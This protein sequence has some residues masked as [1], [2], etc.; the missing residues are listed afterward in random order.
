VSI[1]EQTYYRWRKRYG[2]MG[3]GQLKELKS[4]QKENER[5]RRTVS[6]LTLDNVDLG[7]LCQGELLSLARR[8]KCIDRVRGRFAV[9]ERRIFRV[10]G[11]H[12]STQRHVPRGRS[13]E[14]C[15]VADMTEL[16]RQYDRYGY[17]RI[18]A[19]MREAG[20]VGER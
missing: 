20:W 18:A 8:G 13:D 4:L 19:L 5:L 12:R 2:G 9:S 16:A 3:T 1:T 17:R 14:D 10:L 11:Q 6:D 15:L 7:G